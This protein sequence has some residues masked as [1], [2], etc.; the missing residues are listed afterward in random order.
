[1]WL[2]LSK[3]KPLNETVFWNVLLSLWLASPVKKRRTKIQ[4]KALKL[5]STRYDH[6][7]NKY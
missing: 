6:E 1:M 4:D 7:W 3:R 2:K 5:L